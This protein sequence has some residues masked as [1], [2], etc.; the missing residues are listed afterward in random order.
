[1]LKGEGEVE[2]LE[3]VGEQVGTWGANIPIQDQG[4][5]DNNIRL[6]NHGI[7]QFSCFSIVDAG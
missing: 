2:C 3:E 5:L 1:M 6:F 4:Q 7:T